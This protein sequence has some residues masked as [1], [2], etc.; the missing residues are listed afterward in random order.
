MLTFNTYYPLPTSSYF[1][2]TR[3]QVPQTEVRPVEPCSAVNDPTLLAVLNGGDFCVAGPGYSI[4]L[5]KDSDKIYK[6]APYIVIE[7]DLHEQAYWSPT[8]GWTDP[9]ITHS[10]YQGPG[11]PSYSAAETNHFIPANQGEIY[12]NLVL[13]NLEAIKADQKSRKEKALSKTKR[14]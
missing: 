8:E 11:H 5:R 12:T 7:E 1:S 2:G 9:C 6:H 14:P 3:K 10:V 4:S 13:N